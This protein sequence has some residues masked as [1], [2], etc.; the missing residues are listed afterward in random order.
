LTQRLV[1][2]ELSHEGSCFGKEDLQELQDRA[3]ATRGVR[4]LLGCPPQA[5][6]GLKKL[7]GIALKH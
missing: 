6:A 5:A 4:D 2:R 7:P 3:A 1:L